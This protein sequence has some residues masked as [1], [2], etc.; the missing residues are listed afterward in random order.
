VC[1]GATEVRPPFFCEVLGVLLMNESSLAQERATPLSP[2]SD[3]RPRIFGERGGT[4]ALRLLATPFTVQALDALS[5][6][7]M[8]LSDLRRA[9]EF[10]AQTTMRCHTRVLSKTG[11][12]TKQRGD[13]FP[14]ISSVELGASGRD[15]LLVREVVGKWLERAPAGPIEAGSPAAKRSLKALVEAW[16]SNMMRALA[17]KPLSLTEL[18]SVISGLSYPSLERRLS[19]MRTAGQVEKLRSQ[20]GSSPYA[21]TEWLRRAMAPLIAAVRWERRHIPQETVRIGARDIEAAF[22]LSVPLMAVTPQV[23]GSCRMAVELRSP[24]GRSLSGVVVNLEDGRLTRCTSRLEG[25]C[26]A[27]AIGTVDAWFE[28]V[29]TGDQDG[30]EFGGRRG[31]ARDL[32]EG[33]HQALFG[34]STPPSP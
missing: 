22:L 15:L 28:A 24:K 6:Q 25:G 8:T 16:A 30:L 20:Q 19:A 21:A 9:T 7:A 1:F 17:A 12:L 14:G 23:A 4:Q 27:S 32:I 2:P 18:D 34:L 26:D 11:I 3:Q 33:L 29:S 31:L 13:Q 5:V 10:P